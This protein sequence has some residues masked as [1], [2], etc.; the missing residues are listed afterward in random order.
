MATLE[1]TL[2]DRVDE[3]VG[4]HRHRPFRSTMGTHAA[5]AELVER[6]KGLELAIHELAEE[7]ERL[8]GLVASGRN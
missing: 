2:S 5:I 3:L 6:N 4:A 7:V 1:K 8:K